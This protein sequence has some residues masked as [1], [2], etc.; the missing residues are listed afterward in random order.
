MAMTKAMAARAN[1]ARAKAGYGPMGT[2]GRLSSISAI[3]KITVRPKV[4]A[5]S[6]KGSGSGH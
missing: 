2:K 4:A 6:K 3:G 1:A 5:S